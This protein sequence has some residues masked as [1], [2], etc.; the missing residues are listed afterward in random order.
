MTKRS[1][2]T[3][4]FIFS[5]ILLPSLSC[6]A[7]DSLAVPEGRKY[8]T[9]GFQGSFVSGIGISAGYNEENK[10]RFRVTGG[11]VTSD[12]I[13]YYSFGIE[14]EVDLTKHKPY[15]VF[16]GPG[17]GV[18]GESD[19]DTHATLGIGTGFETSLTGNAMYENV[20]G[21]VEV[22]YPTFYFLTSTIWFGGGIFISYNF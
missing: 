4:V 13:S 22:Y 12:N 15:R 21:G 6:Y 11:L 19:G 7:Q 10:Y 2:L 18:R 17:F 5:S 3:P 14:Y 8:T 20:T 1:F 9:I 16:I